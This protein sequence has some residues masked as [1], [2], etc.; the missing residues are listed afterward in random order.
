MM[1]KKTNA[2]MKRTL[3]DPKRSERPPTFS[4]LMDM[5]GRRPFQLTSARVFPVGPVIV[6]R[7]SSA[8]ERLS[9]L[10]DGARFLRKEGE[11]PTMVGDLGFEEDVSD[12]LGSS[13]GETDVETGRVTILYAHWPVPTSRSVV[14]SI[15]GEVNLSSIVESQGNLRDREYSSGR[16]YNL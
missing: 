13:S 9:E 4:P 2:Y 10:E 15:S 11:D 3:V 6:V 1:Q 5:V 12:K 8:F 14:F 16:E 7:L